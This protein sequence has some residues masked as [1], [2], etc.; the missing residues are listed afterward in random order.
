GTLIWQIKKDGVLQSGSSVV[1][2]ANTPDGQSVNLTVPAGTYNGMSVGA[3]AYTYVSGGPLGATFQNITPSATQTLAP[4]GTITFTFNFT[5]TTG[6]DTISPKVAVISPLNGKNVSG[7]IS[8]YAGATDNVGVAKVE[9]YVD[10]AL[11]ATDQASPYSFLWNTALDSPGSHILTAKAYDA[12]ENAG[13]SSAVTVSVS[14]TAPIGTVTVR[15][16]LNGAPWDGS[17]VVDGSTPNGGSFTSA[18]ISTGDMPNQPIGPYTYTH[19]SGGPTGATLRSVTPYQTQTLT[20][21]GNISFTFNFASTGSVNDTISPTISIASPLNGS[22]VSGAVTISANATDNMGVVKVEFYVDSA[23]KTTVFTS[24]YSYVWFATPFGSHTLTAKAYDAAGNPGQSSAVTVNVPTAITNSAQFISQSVPSSMI[25]GQSYPVSVTMKNIGTNSWSAIGS[26]INAYRLRSENPSDNYNWG[27]SR[28]ELPNTVP[29]GSQVTINFTVTTPSAPGNYNFRWRMIQEGVQAF[30]Q[31]TTN[32]VVVVSPPVSTDTIS[33]AVSITS[34]A[35]GATVSGWVAVNADATDNVGVAKVEFYV[36]GALKATD[37]AIPYSFSWL[38]PLFGSHALTAKAYDA[39][40]NVGQSSTVTVNVLVP[41]VNSAQFV[42]QSVPATMIAG[43]QYPVSVTMKNI[44]TNSWDLIGNQINAYRLRSQNPADNIIWG[45][46]RA[47]LPAAV[48]AGGQVTIN[49]TVTAPSAPGNYNFQWRMIQEGVQAFG[50]Y[51]QNVVVVVSSDAGNDTTPPTVSIISPFNG[52]TVSGPINVNADATDNVAVVKV[53][54]YVDNVLKASALQSPFYFSWNSLLS[55]PGSHTLTAKAYD[56][57]GNVGRSSAVAVNV[58]TAITNSAQ[59]VSQ[60]VPA[61]MI[62]GQQYPVSITMKNIGTNT[63]SPIGNQTNAYR[64]RSENPVDNNAWGTTRA[65][66]P[67][68]VPAGGQV[69]INFTVTAPSAPGNYNFRWRMIQEG[70]QAFGFFTQNV[71]VGVVSAA[72]SSTLSSATV[73]YRATLDGAPWSGDIHFNSHGTNSVTD[74]N[75]TL[76]FPIDIPNSPPGITW[77]ETYVSGGPANA[78]FQNITPSATQG[79]TTGDITFTF[80]FTSNQPLSGQG[81]ICVLSSACSP[82]L[83]CQFTPTPSKPFLRTCQPVSS[84]N[85]S[86]SNLASVLSSMKGILEQM[87]RFLKG[88]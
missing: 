80:N 39:A 45:I 4:N 43:R 59:F 50:L 21:G 37:Q 25:A 28:A 18:N 77:T 9:F 2:N 82:G 17:F 81:T 88:Y 41:I 71:A 46:S 86:A 69:T 63:W 15:A 42:S 27:I 52:A 22:T 13:Q 24:P 53:E 1:V 62:A 84:S 67:N 8:V 83:T 76:T 85:D 78:T 48:P 19:K 79:I 32:S 12:A 58:P 16:T 7:Q 30:G 11:K 68:T 38:T 3:Y 56:A 74:W 6:S 60:S 47:E 33:P 66:L 36:D 23:L 57:A 5:T 31:L 54:F 34:P 72:T 44:G 51:T 75:G 26:Q 65:E 73:F 87:S 35:N 10:G 64:L 20:S 61:T 29:A 49:F 55:L 14:N 40:G 70:V